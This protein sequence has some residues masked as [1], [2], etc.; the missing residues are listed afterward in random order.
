[1]RQSNYVFTFSAKPPPTKAN[2]LLVEIVEFA[3]VF[4]YKDITNLLQPPS[5]KYI[6][7]LKPSTRP[8]Y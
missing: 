7:D 3:N 2:E 6:I 4:T 8:P 5:T 1:M